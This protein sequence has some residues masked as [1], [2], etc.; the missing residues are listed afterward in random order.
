MFGNFAFSYSKRKGIE[1]LASLFFFFSPMTSLE[2]Q[3]EKVKLSLSNHCGTTLCPDASAPGCTAL[4]ERLAPLLSTPRVKE[5]NVYSE[6]WNSCANLSLF[7][8]T[9]EHLERQE[10]P[11]FMTQRL[12]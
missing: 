2:F 7:T 3:A 10:H 6:A 4:P 1:I 11:N 9:P 5:G 8:T 12:K